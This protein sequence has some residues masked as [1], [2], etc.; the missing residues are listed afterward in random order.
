VETESFS[1]TLCFQKL[2]D[3]QL[4]KELSKR[5]RTLKTH[6]L[7]IC[8]ISDVVLSF[9][10]ILVPSS[11]GLSSLK[12]ENC[13]ILKMEAPQSFETSGTTWLMTQCHIPE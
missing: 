2:K 3:G 5:K 11:S 9:W 12:G 6:F 1:E 4:L 8:I 7:V 10:R 13:L